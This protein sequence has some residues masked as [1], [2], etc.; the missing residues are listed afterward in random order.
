MHQAY[1]GCDCVQRE[2][3]E[4]AKKIHFYVCMYVQILYSCTHACMYVIV[5]NVSIRFYVCMYAQILYSCIHACMYV[6]V[7]N[8]SIRFYVRMYAQTLYSCI[9]VCT[10]ISRRCIYTYIY[11]CMHMIIFHCYGS[12]GS[13]RICM[14]TYIHTEYYC[15]HVYVCMYVRKHMKHTHEHSLS[16]LLCGLPQLFA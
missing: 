3:K 4:N 11:V 5:C 1:D 15:M 6:I 9:H 16:Q 13:S 14:H 10:Y 8:V 7:C 12:C 2:Y